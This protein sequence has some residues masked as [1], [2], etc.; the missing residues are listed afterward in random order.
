MP[1]ILLIYMNNIISS[2]FYFFEEFT[3]KLGIDFVKIESYLKNGFF[4]F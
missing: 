2:N 4:F 3:N 1:I